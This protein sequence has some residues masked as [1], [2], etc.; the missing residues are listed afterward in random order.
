DRPGAG[1]VG[2]EA[3]DFLSYNT[4]I[5][6]CAAAGEAGEAKNTREEM[7]A[8]GIP[9]DAYTYE[10][11]AMGC[12]L[13]GDW[14]TAEG[15]VREMVAG[16]AEERRAA[17]AG[18]AS[19]LP[20]SSSASPSTE[21]GTAAAEA[22]AAVA[23][24]AEGGTEEVAAAA[25]AAVAGAGDSMNRKQRHRQ[26]RRREQLKNGVPPSPRVLH[27]LMEA[28]ARA[29]EWERAQECLDDMLHGSKRWPAAGAESAADGGAREEQERV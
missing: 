28:Y 20:P 18:A 19:P 27:G 14:E 2:E 29:G 11:L 4:V 7:R 3:L 23:P 1:G 17:A 6:A 24:S 10:A 8:A 22:A 5:R 21:R 26:R 15:I 16:C 13:A 25:A 12:G 9:A